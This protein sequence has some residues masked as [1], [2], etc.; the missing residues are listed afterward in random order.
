MFLNKSF[1]KYIVADKNNIPL[2]A[3]PFQRAVKDGVMGAFHHR[4]FWHPMDTLRDNI[5]LNKLWDEGNPPWLKIQ[6][7]IS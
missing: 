3:E 2:E 5:K 6:P 7:Q 1:L 4:G